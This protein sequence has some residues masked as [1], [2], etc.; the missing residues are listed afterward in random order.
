M[1]ALPDFYWLKSISYPWSQS[2]GTCAAVHL[3]NPFTH[4]L[5][6]SNMTPKNDSS[7]DIKGS[8]LGKMACL[9][10]W[11][12]NTQGTSWWAH[13]TICWNLI[14]E[15]LLP[16]ADKQT[17]NEG[18]SSNFR[19]SLLFSRKGVINSFDSFILRLYFNIGM[20][21]TCSSACIFNS[22]QQHLSCVSKNK[23]SDEGFVNWKNHFLFWYL[24]LM[25]LE[26][27]PGL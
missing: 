15:M 5:A 23:K 11:P 14:M 16:D 26:D 22:W 9:I 1:R 24:S 27:C 10:T 7:C 2:Q 19:G 21:G 18:K 3:L 8:K 6:T 20:F 13:I 12:R 17:W 4:Q 25:S